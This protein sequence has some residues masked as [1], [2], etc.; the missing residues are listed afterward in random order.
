MWGEGEVWA[1]IM[2]PASQT[3]GRWCGPQEMRWAMRGDALD[4]P[5][6]HHARC[7]QVRCSRSPN[8]S[9]RPMCPGKMPPIPQSLT[10]PDVPR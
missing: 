6:T 10:T 5:I 4:H 8:H 1:V 3:L 9:P 2:K 7:A